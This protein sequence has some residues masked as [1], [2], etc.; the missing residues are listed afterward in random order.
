MDRYE[1]GNVF[2]RDGKDRG[3]PELHRESVGEKSPTEY[4]PIASLLPADSP[5]LSGEDADHIRMLASV[6]SKL[7]PILVHRSTMRIIDGMHR[8]GA[9]QLRNETMIEVRFF[10]GSEDEAFVLAVKANIAHGRPLSLADRSMAAE[11]IITSHPAWS[12]RAIAASAG[13]GA[14]SV[15]EI[16]ARIAGSADGPD[17][18]KARI[19][20]DG[21]V[22]PLDHSEGRLKAAEII[23]EK[24]GASLREIARD[25]GVS[26]AT[27]LDVR[28][29][30]ERGADP[31][32]PPR[33]SLRE[34]P[35]PRARR[36]ESDQAAAE[37]NLINML[38]GLKSDPSLRFTES[39]RATLRWTLS[40]AVLPGEWSEHFNNVPTH[41]A[42]LLATVARQCANQWLQIADDLDQQTTKT[43]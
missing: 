22:R 21:R 4:L 27:A 11:R 35:K 19:G 12:D 17:Q 34:A 8:L 5:R 39:G 20:R 10:D 26:P 24:P 7:P 33:R 23:R 32:P 31:V 29:R 37:H 2:Q 43:A 40:R 41:C 1:F 28:K 13:L 6:D 18:I 3:I 38:Q 15:A 36:F 16:R 42:Y 14:K 9:A 30:L 25:S